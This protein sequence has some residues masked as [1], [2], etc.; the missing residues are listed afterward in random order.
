MQEFQEITDWIASQRHTFHRIAKVS[1]LPSPEFESEGRTMVSFSSNNYLALANDPRMIAAAQKGLH[2]FGVANCESRLLGGDMDIYLDLEQE[3]ASIKGKETAMLYATGY[4]TNL[5]VLSALPNSGLL[6]RAYGFRPSKRRRYMYFSDEFNHT[7]IREG[8]SLSGVPK[9]VYR[10]C[11]L[12][13]LRKKLQTAPD[14]CK[15]IVSDGVFSMD[16]DIAPLPQLIEL[17]EEFDA[18]LYI[19]DAHGT[20]VLGAT[21]GGITEHF[22]VNSPRLISMGT[23]SKAYGA[24]GGFIATERYIADTLRFTSS[25]FG[26]TSTMPPDQ[27]L[28]VSMALRIIKSEPQR[29]ER[30]WANQRYFAAQVEAM[31]LSLVSKATCIVPVLIGDEQRCEEFAYEL[32]ERGYHVDSII[33]PAVKRGMARLR[34]NM[35]ANHTKAHIDGLL[36]VLAEMSNQAL[37]LTA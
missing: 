6:P 34:F 30:L 22:G 17:A 20:G 28:A 29:R 37:Q 16:G 31:G 25:A 5:G 35:N 21:G 7:S 14:A 19:D 12:D 33:Y 10:H 9:V 18:T 15:I 36:G 13:D 24:I 3:L 11:D 26:F 1:S 23:L 32:G 27:V 2:Q 4:L 8:I